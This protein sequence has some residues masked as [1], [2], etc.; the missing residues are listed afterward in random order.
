MNLRKIA[1]ASIASSLMIIPSI[2]TAQPPSPL[3]GEVWVKKGLGPF[4]CEATVTFT[5]TQ[6]TLSVTG[7]GPFDPTD[8]C[9]SFSFNSSP[10]SYSYT[11]ATLGTSGTLT[12]YGVNITTTLTPGT[13]GDDLSIEVTPTGDY[14]IQQSLPWLTGTPLNCD[15]EGVLN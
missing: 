6:A 1:L 9:N 2:A 12:I 7:W 5:S 11:P 3:T 10:Y 15:V 4:S 13:C 8:P 14:I